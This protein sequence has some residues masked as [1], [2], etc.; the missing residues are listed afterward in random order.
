MQASSSRLEVFIADTESKS[1][2][3]PGSSLELASKIIR[4][5]ME[6]TRA[7]VGRI[8]LVLH[9][10]ATNEKPALELARHFCRDQWLK[11]PL[12]RP[13]DF[14]LHAQKQYQLAGRWHINSWI[15]CKTAKLK[16][17]VESVVFVEQDLNTVA[18][19]LEKQDFSSEQIEQFFHDCIS[20]FDSILHLYFPGGES[21][22]S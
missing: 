19:E 14:E 6:N 18:E 16:P 15:R 21:C 2:V 8:A 22:M 17:S 5:Y 10:A 9:R 7:I 1:G 3:E 12:N 11:G 13:E 20:E 4:R